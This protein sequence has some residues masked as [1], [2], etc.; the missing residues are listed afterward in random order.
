[1]RIL[2][3]VVCLTVAVGLL[4]GCS[5]QARAPQP[6]RSPTSA[7]PTPRPT[8]TDDPDFTQPGVARSM[9]DTL[10]DAAGA[11]DA[12]MVA[13]ARHEIRVA[14]VTDGAIETWAYRD[15]RVGTVE[16]D[17]VDVA[18]AAFTPGDYALDDIG[19]LF[20][21]AHAVAGSNASQ[22]LQIVDYSGGVV[23]MTVTTTPESRT[24]FFTPDGRLVP[25]LDPTTEWGISDAYAEALGDRMSATQVV[26]SSDEG[27]YLQTTDAEAGT[28]TRYQRAP[29][30][31]LL[32]T[33]RTET[34]ALPPMDPRTV[35]P[36]VVWDVLAE[37]HHDGDFRY[38]EAWTCVID[39]REGIGVARMYFQ[40]GSADP[41]TTTLDGD[42]VR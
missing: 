10:M 2:G 8:P 12:V 26:F 16:S 33:T 37:A 18:Q 22:E 41:F 4:S 14:V 7:A 39:D 38:D 36:E 17:I 25:T 15:G 28:I 24:V 42:R 31:P 34:S 11:T 30:T 13:I 29:R 9:V 27:A 3:A 35:R 19:S 21:A 6:T 40:L 23:A 1:M 5:P 20:R 32:I